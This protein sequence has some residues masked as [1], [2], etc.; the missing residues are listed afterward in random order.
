[1]LF[2]NY[3]SAA[4]IFLVAKI[5]VEVASLEATENNDT[6]HVMSIRKIQVKGAYI[7]NKKRSLH[8]NAKYFTRW[9][10]STYRVLVLKTDLFLNLWTTTLTPLCWE[11]AT[12]R[13]IA[14]SGLTSMR[15]RVVQG[16]SLV[17]VFTPF[18]FPPS[19]AERQ[20]SHVPLAHWENRWES[21]KAA[22]RNGHVGTRQLLPRLGTRQVQWLSKESH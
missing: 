14:S 6:S 10:S 7:C 2:A 11:L 8:R 3:A 17:F 1:M 21:E 12:D 9:K 20:F 16:S 4:A 15:N 18:S 13:L 5:E 22:T 19:P